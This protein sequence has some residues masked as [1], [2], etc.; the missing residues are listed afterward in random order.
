MA[1]RSTNSE[2]YR[3]V[4]ASLVSEVMAGAPAA[5][6]EPKAQAPVSLAPEPRAVV[7]TPP[8]AAAARWERSRV[9]APT[10]PHADVEQELSFDKSERF[11]REK[12]VMLTVSE[13]ERV[14]DLVR[15]IAR[16][17]RTPV[18]LSHLLRACLGLVL[19]SREELLAQAREKPVGRP[20]NGDT[21]GIQA[22]E[23]SLG[24]LLDS[25]MRLTRP[26][27]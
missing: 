8:A 19:R 12:R 7:V 20:P 1:K 9:S 5:P 3:P 24:A 18:K 10:A 4:R 17:L 23:R 13:E 27:T 22:F 11:S 2:P 14:E 26:P 16:E 6:A 21:A 25:A 15:S